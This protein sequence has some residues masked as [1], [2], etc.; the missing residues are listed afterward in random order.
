MLVN[1]LTSSLSITSCPPLFLAFQKNNVLVIGGDMNVQK[2]K[3]VNKKFSEHN[4]SNR[5][6]EHLRYFTLENRWTCLHTKFQKTK[7]KL[8][9][10]TYANSTKAQMD[11]IF[12]KKKWNNSALNCKAYSSFKGVC[13]DYGIVTRR[14]PLRLRRDNNNNSTLWLVPDEQQG[15]SR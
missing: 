15:Y 7:G 2:G 5:N 12:I 8:W 13:F 11:N 14:I 1:K 3:N 4:S 10:S 6:G 9:T